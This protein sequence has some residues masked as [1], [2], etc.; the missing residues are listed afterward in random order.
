TALGRW[1]EAVAV[2]GAAGDGARRQQAR[3]LLWQA[4]AAEGAA[5]LGARR[6][7]EARRAFDAARA[8]A[9][10]VVA[11]G[12]E[13]SLRAA[14]RAGVDR[15]APARPAPSARQAAK[16]ASGGLTR[17]ERETAALVAR[18]HSNRAIG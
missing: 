6:R 3:G 10:E 13:P 7:R 5:H 8:T 11:G 14:F 17:R 9:L 15:S 1:D 12:D 4:R 2:S 18:G 16:A